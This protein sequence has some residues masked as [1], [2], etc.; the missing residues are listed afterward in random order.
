MSGYWNIM[1]GYVLGSGVFSPD[2]E[3]ATNVVHYLQQHGALIMGMY[4][5]HA[6]TNNFWLAG[7]KINDLYGMRYALLMQR[8]DE[9][10]R[11]LIS[12]YGKLAQGFTRDTFIG[13]EGSDIMPLDELGR[14]MY[15]PPNSAANSNWL[16]QCRYLMVQDYDLDDDGRADTLRLA[17]ATPRA[18]MKSGSRLRV[19]NAPTEFGKVSY[20]IE[21]ALKD[22]H[23]DAEVTIPDRNPPQKVLLRLRLPDGAKV[24]S[25][26]AN[27]NK[28]NVEQSEKGETIDLS[29][30]KGKVRVHAQVGK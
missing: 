17:F 6:E 15:L 10:D 16:Q 21:S 7:R 3:T 30:L 19:S 20:V 27:G 23:V 24:A 4:S 14:Q 11:A 13:G 29:G 26:T 22:G 8:R 2:S 9:P 5:T 25:A 18:W 12:F 28:A 1:M